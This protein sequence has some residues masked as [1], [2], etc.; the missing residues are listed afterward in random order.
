MQQMKNLQQPHM[1]LRLL[2][3][4]EYMIFYFQLYK[5]WILYFLESS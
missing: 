4:K 2:S 5:E 1:T 3:L